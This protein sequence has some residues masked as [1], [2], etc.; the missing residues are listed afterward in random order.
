MKKITIIGTGYV[1]LVSGSGLADFGNDVTCLDVNSQRIKILSEG[2]IPFFEPGLSELVKRNVDAN[3][4]HFS[5]DLD[6]SLYDSDVIFIAVGTP[7]DDSGASDISAVE[8]V[9]VDIA[10]KIT[11]YKV[12]AIKSTVPIGTCKKIE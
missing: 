6:K 10:K 12:I 9:A 1:G 8:K 11:S 7:M 5:T 4:L 2:K 3:R